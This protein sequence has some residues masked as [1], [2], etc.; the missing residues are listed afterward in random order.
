MTVEEAIAQLRNLAKC[1]G[2]DNPRDAE[3]LSVLSGLAEENA[4][5]KA[6]RSLILSPPAAIGHC[7]GCGA[8][9]TADDLPDLGG[10]S[11]MERDAR[12]EPY[13]VL[14]G[15]IHSIKS[16]PPKPTVSREW[17]L[18]RAHDIIRGRDSGAEGAFEFALNDL[19]ITVEE[20]K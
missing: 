14:C 15:P 9:L 4:A 18:K 6:V 12:G 7:E 20:E 1:S 10:H 5:L 19:G 11:R 16:V 2:C 13:G 3:A 17:F 8:Y